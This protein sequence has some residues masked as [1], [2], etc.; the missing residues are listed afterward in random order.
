MA[1][2]V[3]TSRIGLVFALAAAFGAL[4]GVG[5]YAVSFRAEIPVG[6]TQ[7]ALAALI[8]G[9]ALVLRSARRAALAGAASGAFA[10]HRRG[11]DRRDPCTP[12]ASGPA[13]VAR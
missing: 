10:P 2:L 6:A 13:R 8:L 11:L 1:A 3:L 5:G 9:A 12:A 4:S 7:T